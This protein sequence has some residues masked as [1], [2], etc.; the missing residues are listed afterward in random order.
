MGQGD[1]EWDPTGGRGRSGH[2]RPPFGDTVITAWH[3]DRPAVTELLDT[4]EWEVLRARRS[5]V[6]TTPRGCGRSH[7]LRLVADRVNPVQWEAVYVPNPNVAAG[8]FLRLLI[9]LLG[10]APGGLEPGAVLE[11]RLDALWIEG[12][13]LLV[14]IDDAETMPEA[15]RRAVLDLAARRAPTIVFLFGLPDTAGDAAAFVDGP[16]APPVARLASAMTLEETAAYVHH[17]LRRAGAGPEVVD[18]FSDEVIGHLY[19]MSEGV[20]AWLHTL[21]QVLV[22]TPVDAPTD[23]WSRFLRDERGILELA[24]EAVRWLERAEQAAS[25]A[26]REVE[27]PASARER[28]LRRVAKRELLADAS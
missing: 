23:A 24:S 2:G 21:A 11:H 8:E 27:T 19:A 28:E 17:R 16:A 13:S 3:R 12:R 15:S 25:D 5:G 4:L 7:L 18:R 9:G 20:P 14:A 1:T 10:I 26:A 6:L 22:E